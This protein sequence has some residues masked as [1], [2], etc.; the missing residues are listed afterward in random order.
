MQQATSEK[1]TR[2][3]TR[4]NMHVPQGVKMQVAE[5]GLQP[6]S[7]ILRLHGIMDSQLAL[8]GTVRSRLALLSGAPSSSGLGCWRAELLLILGAG[9]GVGSAPGPGGALALWRQAGAVHLPRQVCHLLAAGLLLSP[10]R[11]H[12]TPPQ[13]SHEWVLLMQ[14]HHWQSR[15]LCWPASSQ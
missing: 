10:L 6:G 15:L 4:Y 8:H 11:L 3:K 7:Q 13:D 5:S 9:A 2:V 1:L 12:T 14:K